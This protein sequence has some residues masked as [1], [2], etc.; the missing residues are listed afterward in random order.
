MTFDQ[1]QVC[2]ERE[3]FVSRDLPHTLSSAINGTFLSARL[4]PFPVGQRITL[5]QLEFSSEI[6]QTLVEM[7][8]RAQVN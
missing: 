3:C 5:K 8:L 1:I 6:R 4:R 2:S 7:S